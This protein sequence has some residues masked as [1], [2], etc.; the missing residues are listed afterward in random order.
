M[1]KAVIYHNTKCSK[2]NAALHFLLER[3]IQTNIIN[4]LETPPSSETL[5]TLLNQLAIEAKALIRFGE[6]V[7]KE[8]NLSIDDIRTEQEWVALMVQHS[9]LIERPIVVI[10]NKAVIARPA[11]LLSDFIHTHI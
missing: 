8:L 1:L 9:S 10:N 6:P 4:Y 2:S 3:G 11:E 7:A 5:K